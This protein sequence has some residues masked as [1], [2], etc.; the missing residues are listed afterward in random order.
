[1]LPTSRGQ[2]ATYCSF[3]CSTCF[4]PGSTSPPP[5]TH[6]HI[7]DHIQCNHISCYVGCKPYLE[8]RCILENGNNRNAH[9]YVRLG[10]RKPP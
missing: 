4:K 6:T 8:L 10:A 9:T 2:M 5:H 7:I 3:A 1:M